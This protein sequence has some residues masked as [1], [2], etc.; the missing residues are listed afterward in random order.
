MRMIE[1]L[2]DVLSYEFT[3]PVDEWVM[4][5][6]RKRKN[7]NQDYFEHLEEFALNHITYGERKHGEVEEEWRHL[8]MLLAGQLC[9]YKRGYPFPT[10]NILIL[11]DQALILEHEGFPIPN[12]L[13]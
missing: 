7:R 11:L 5:H 8:K 2:E 3:Y 4:L 1:C 9:D 12:L 10:I 6:F 13:R